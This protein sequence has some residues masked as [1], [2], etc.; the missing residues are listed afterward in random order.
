VLDDRSREKRRDIRLQHDP[1]EGKS[2]LTPVRRLFV[3]ILFLASTAAYAGLSSASHS[4]F[5]PASL[6]NDPGQ[7][8]VWLTPN[9]TV[10]LSFLKVTHLL[11]TDS[12]FAGFR[13]ATA[14]ELEMLYAEAGIPN[15]NFPGFG[16]LYG[17]SDNVSSVE[18]LQGLVGVTYS[19]QVAGQTLTETAGFVGDSFTSPANGFL[20]VEIG[21]LVVRGNVPT[22][23]GPMSFASAY[24]NWG[25]LPIGSQAVGV[26]T[27]LVSSVPEPTDFANLLL[28]LLVLG[29]SRS[30]GGRP[31]AS[32]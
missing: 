14:S 5:G 28:G 9:A 10:G 27:W 31:T 22:S 7:G 4:I 21:N 24:T 3:S 25:S 2:M 32:P 17:T 15:V 18:Y 8:L 12:R 11:A 30:R 6:T 16:A 26:G 19:V 23:F 29:V 13:V 1:T 20:S